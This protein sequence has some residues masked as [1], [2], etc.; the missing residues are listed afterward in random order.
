MKHV[1]HANLLLTMSHT[2]VSTHQHLHRCIKSNL[3]TY[4]NIIVS[5]IHSPTTRIKPCFIFYEYT[6]KMAQPQVQVHTTATTRTYETGTYPAQQQHLRSK[7][8]VDYPYYHR[9][10]DD[11][12]FTSLFPER[13]PSASQILASL[14]GLF[15]GGTL[16]LLASFS[17]FASLIGLTIMTPLFILFS[18]ILVPAALT[19]GLAVA[20]VLTANACGLTGLMSVSWTVRYIRDLQ[21]AVPGQIDMK[22]R[23]ADVVDYVGQ[24]TKDVGQKTKEVGQDIQTK[25]H[26]AK[27]TT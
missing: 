24:K 11:S 4:T 6:Q 18:P 15:L 1:P 23:M 27:R 26:E 17:F 10:N 5:Y 3:H 13:G 2:L 12:G 22:G 9:S 7:E 14:G 25:A 19:I 20:G 21:A 8:G 16:L